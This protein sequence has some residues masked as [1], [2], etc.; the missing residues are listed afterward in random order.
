MNASTKWLDHVETKCGAIAKRQFEKAMARHSTNLFVENILADNQNIMRDGVHYYGLSDK[1]NTLGRNQD[2]ARIAADD[3]ANGN[4]VDWTK[5]QFLTNP[6]MPVDIKHDLFHKPG[7]RVTCGPHQIFT[8]EFD[9]KDLGFFNQQLTWFRYSGGELNCAIGKLFSALSSSYADFAGISA[10]YSGNKSFHIH[11]AFDPSAARTTYNL[12]EA[13]V[14]LRSGFVAHWNILKDEVLRILQPTANGQA[15]EPDHALRYPESYR[16]LPGG[17]RL[18]EPKPNKPDWRHALDIPFGTTV[19]QVIM[20]QKFRDRAASGATELFFRPCPFRAEKAGAAKKRNAQSKPATACRDAFSDDE[21]AF[22]EENLR[23]LFPKGVYPE[24]VNLG[25]ESG[26]WVARFRNSAT[27]VT[28][29]SIMTEEHKE[30]LICGQS[31][32]AIP[33]KAL[34]QP[35]LAMMRLWK[36]Q[37]HKLLADR[38]LAFCIGDETQEELDYEIKAKH[39]PGDSPL[40][41]QF[42]AA[43]VDK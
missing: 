33:A 10:C 21:F 34:P 31:V 35:L 1:A 17:T 32:G 7:Q 22:I 36:A 16:R 41:Q 23:D 11:V 42:S 12:S 43:A 5:Y 3:L 18:I 9:E 38:D 26:K 24:F 28:P 2:L 39:L 13:D 29:S 40:E 37:Y 27:D 30:V 25:K 19:P 6:L 14:D 8:Y 4:A 20:W 15:V